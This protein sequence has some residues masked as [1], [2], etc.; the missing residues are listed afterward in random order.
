MKV[1]TISLHAKML[2]PGDT[3]GPGGETAVAILRIMDR[4]RGTMFIQLPVETPIEVTD[5]TIEDGKAFTRHLGKLDTGCRITSA[6][7]EAEAEDED[8][9]QGESDD[10]QPRKSGSRGRGHHR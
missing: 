3:V 8:K 7:E 5:E 2:K 1:R 6:A 4:D 10:R 9:G